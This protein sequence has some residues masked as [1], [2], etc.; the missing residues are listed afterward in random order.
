M[1]WQVSKEQIKQ[2]E[3]KENEL[4]FNDLDLDSIV[5]TVIPIYTLKNPNPK[6]GKP[7][8]PITTREKE[9]YRTVMKLKLGAAK[10]EQERKKW[11]D[12]YTKLFE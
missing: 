1:S 4:F 7:D 11:I 5:S 9:H 12:H 8:C 3:N 6:S 2:L 10:T